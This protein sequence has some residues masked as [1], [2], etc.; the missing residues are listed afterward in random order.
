[1]SFLEYKT[2]ICKSGASSEVVEEVVLLQKI[3]PN[4]LV[5]RFLLEC[6]YAAFL[7]GLK[8]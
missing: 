1:M 4:T 8:K 6:K 2:H 3:N 7:V 5:P